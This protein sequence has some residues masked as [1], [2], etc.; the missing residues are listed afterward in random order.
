[1]KGIEI[2]IRERNIDRDKLIYDLKKV[3]NK[4]NSNKLSKKEYQDN[5]GQYSE[6]VFRRR[7]GSWSDALKEAQLEIY[8]N[9]IRYTEL[10]LYTNY[11]NVCEKLRKQ[12]S[13]RDMRLKISNISEA[14]YFSHFGSW[15]EFL[16]KFIDYLNDGKLR[17]E[18]DLEKTDNKNSPRSI[19]LSLRY[20][21]LVRDN[22]SC[23]KCGQSPAKNKKI[24]LHIDHI[25]PFSKGGA[26]EESNLEVKCS[27]CNY[28]KS[29]NYSI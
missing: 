28:G 15:N 10:Q 4:I 17:V 9:N 14:T 3:A 21:I 20:K 25:I 24:I 22:F 23:K 11:I 26:T 12:A 5:G 8:T 18:V 19:P 1:L 13:S 29:N 16:T 7:F 2:K 27:D 6:G